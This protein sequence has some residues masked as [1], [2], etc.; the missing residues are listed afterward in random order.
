[1]L[2]YVKWRLAVWQQQHPD[3]PSP[4]QVILVERA[5]TILPPDDDTGNVWDGPRTVPLMRWQPQAVWQEGYR[6]IERYNPVTQRFETMQ[7]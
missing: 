7:K 2:A 5:Y 3:R 4:R 6:P 1:M